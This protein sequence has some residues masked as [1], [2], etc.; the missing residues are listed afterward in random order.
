LWGIDV[1]D[2][3]GHTHSLQRRRMGEQDEVRRRIHSMRYIRQMLEWG[4]DKEFIAR[5]MGV[6]L[7]SLEVRLNRAKKREQDGKSGGKTSDE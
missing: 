6:N 3:D 7:A 5:D 1:A 4:F 2:M